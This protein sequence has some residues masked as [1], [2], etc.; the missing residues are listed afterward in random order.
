MWLL[1]GVAGVTKKLN[2]NITIG[3]ILLYI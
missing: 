2:Y 1:P 3:I